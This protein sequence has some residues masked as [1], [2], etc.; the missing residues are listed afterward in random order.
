MTAPRV[1]DPRIEALFS[2]LNHTSDLNTGRALVATLWGSWCDRINARTGLPGVSIL[3]LGEIESLIS[4]FFV[5]VS[6]PV[7]IKATQSLRYD[8]LGCKASKQATNYIK[9]TEVWFS[10][11]ARWVEIL[12]LYKACR[13]F[14][15]KM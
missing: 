5:S 7:S 15:V 14:D 9:E 1:R 10:S 3:W 4:N 8:L 2:Q 13:S 12:N 11:D 6:A